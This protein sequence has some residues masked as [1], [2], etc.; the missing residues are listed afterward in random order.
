MS[1]TARI[2][3]IEKISPNDG[4]GLRTVVFF[5]GCPLRCRWCS[6]PESQKRTFELY[7]R[8]V[9]CLHCGT[10]V[11]TCPRGLLEMGEKGILTG[12]RNETCA[13]C[14]LCAQ[15]CPAGA[16]GVYGA[17]MTVAQVMKQILKDEVFYFHSGGGVTLSGGDVLLQAEFAADLLQECR[18]NGIHTM[19]ELD[20]Y[21]DFSNIRRLLPCLNGLYVDI[22]HMDPEQHKYWTG[23][24]NREILENIRKTADYFRAHNRKTEIHFRIPLIWGVNDSEEN[25]LATAEFCRETGA[26]EE[27]EFLPYHRLGES[28]YEYLGRTYEFAGKPKMTFEDAFQRVKVLQGKEL[29]FPVKISGKEVF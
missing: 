7:Y 8:Q 20:M 28:T 21:G 10:C 14:F 29:P 15:A 9:K 24:D 2:L 3:R 22:K 13:D 23:V 26:C 25:I 4:R 19:A 6:T 17:E 27:L 16:L 1:R 5:K 18:D 11:K 12:Y